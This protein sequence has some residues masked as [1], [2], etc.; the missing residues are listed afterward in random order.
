MLHTSTHKEKEQN[1]TKKICIE[2]QKMLTNWDTE[3]AGNS[4]S[5]KIRV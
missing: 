2:D 3:R 1:F 4:V 5:E